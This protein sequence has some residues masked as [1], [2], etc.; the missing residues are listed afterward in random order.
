MIISPNFP[1]PFHANHM[2]TSPHKILHLEFSYKIFPKPSWI[3]LFTPFFPHSPHNCMNFFYIYNKQMFIHP[4]TWEIV[5]F[6]MHHIMF[7][8]CLRCYSFTRILIFGFCKYGFLSF[9]IFWWPF[10]RHVQ[11]FSF[12]TKKTKFEGSS[13]T[14]SILTI[15][16]HD[17]ND[18]IPSFFFCQNIHNV[19]LFLNTA[20]LYHM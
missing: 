15:I 12:R 20:C 5:F 11:F 6:I 8:N 17:L 18:K 19:V 2:K 3:C 13:K 4:N 1:F 14:T 9:N 10:L 16:E 7:S